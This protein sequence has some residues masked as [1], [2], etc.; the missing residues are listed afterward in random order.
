M[1]GHDFRHA[2]KGYKILGFSPED[3]SASIAARGL[4]KNGDSYM[5]PQRLKPTHK[6]R[7]CGTDK[8]VP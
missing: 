1:S 4:P 2:V 5:E 3:A 6:N 7:S 8:S